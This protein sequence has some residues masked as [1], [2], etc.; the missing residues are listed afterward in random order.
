VVDPV[1]EGA[2]SLTLAFRG[3]RRDLAVGGEPIG[4]VRA[5]FVRAVVLPLPMLFFQAPPGAAPDFPLF[6]AEHERIRGRQSLV[7]GVLA[8]EA[9]GGI[10]VVN[11]LRIG[12]P[13]PR[14]AQDLFLLARAGVPVPRTLVTSSPEEAARFLDSVQDAVAKPLQGRHAAVRVTA[15]HRARIPGD[16]VR[17]TVVGDTVVSACRIDSR[18]AGGATLDFRASARY[19]RGEARYERVRL[20][21]DVRRACLRAARTLGLAFTGID[22]KLGRGGRFA[23]L[24][25]NA[26]PA[27]LEFEQRSGDPITAHLAAHLVRR[28]REAPRRPRGE[29]PPRGGDPPPWAGYFFDY[30]PPFASGW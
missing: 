24:E 27:Y 14:K 3:G 16:D 7:M 6:W 21:A 19:T 29:A 10:P 26:S 5:W 4:D 25:A 20:P 30:L 28:A 22:V 23:I 18:D 17:V 9:E 15:E 11:P 13:E 1:A 2:P 12:S 8:A